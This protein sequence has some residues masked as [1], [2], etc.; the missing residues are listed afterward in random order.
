MERVK[1][2]PYGN[3]NF[4][5]M[6]TE[7]YC[8]IDKTAYI[9]MLEREPN[10]F[11][12]FIRPRKFGKSLFFTTLNHYYNL[13]GAENFPTLFGDL[14]I[15]SHPT[16]RHNTYLMMM[17]D[18]SGLNTLTK[19]D[20]IADFNRRIESS[21]YGFLSEYRSL[22]PD[23]KTLIR[24]IKE[25][26]TGGCTALTTACQVAKDIGR[27][28]FVIIDEYDHFAND[29]IAMGVDEVYKGVIRANG[30]VR[31]FYERLKDGT[32]TV[33]DRI[34]ITGISPVMM[35]DLTSGFNIAKN[36]TNELRYNE[37][38]G[39]TA[40]EVHRLME[41]TGVDASLINVD[42]AAY[43][44]GYLFHTDAERTLYNPSMLMFFF[45]QII[46]NKKPPKQ[47]IDDNLKT[48]YG[49]IERLVMNE[50]N[51][52]RLEQI[53]REGR[54]AS[55]V[56]TKFSIDRLY[57]NEYFVS[58]LY[59]M[60]L[61]TFSRERS[62]LPYLR[63]PNYSIETLYWE[64]IFRLMVNLNEKVCTDGSELLLSVGEL[65]FRGDPQRY[66]RY[67]SRYILK[68]LSNRDLMKF[69]EKYIK[70]ILLHGLL[71][72]GLY[73]PKSEYEIPGGYADI[74]M[75]RSPVKPD[76]PFEWLWEIKYLP[77]S[78]AKNLP[79]IIRQ[80][81][82]QLERYRQAPEF[83][84]RT[85]MRYASVIFIGKRRFEIVA[86]PDVPAAQVYNSI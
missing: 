64:Y 2:L 68:N 8:Y 24:E 22:I 12:F 51:R 31:D 11:Q 59:Y 73:V 49:R 41:E 45:D 44:D 35:D 70:I 27:K 25:A 83:T 40:A 61:L 6:I 32:K 56:I 29:L 33:I 48:D 19:E 60:G 30:I 50:Q 46:S 52:G 55:E 86:L 28:I 43:Y 58:L 16:A 3:C 7:N 72:S 1:L 5:K 71:Q 85:D 66:V 34:F 26:N 14:Y 75:K 79:E 17:F 18:F 23:A 36:L 20:F 62:G 21:V 69:D 76:I 10:G 84:G 39:F 15:G 63:I 67:V 77:E 78:R 54:T 4:E 13:N 80:A 47:L 42:M 37:M 38:M 9:E 57:D 82:Q 53:I 74:Y 65:A 81:R